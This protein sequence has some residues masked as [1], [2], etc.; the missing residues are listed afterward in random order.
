MQNHSC[1]SEF[2]LNWPFAAVQ[3]RGIITQETHRGEITNCV[4][5]SPLGPKSDH[6]QLS[7][8]YINTS[9]RERLGESVRINIMITKGKMLI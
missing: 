7:P 9:S 5:L 2:H 4:S 8:D 6:Y 1:D 3:S